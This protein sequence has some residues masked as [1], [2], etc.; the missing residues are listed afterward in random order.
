MLYK[1]KTL[2]VP[3]KTEAHTGFRQAAPRG[4][5]V[6]FVFATTRLQVDNMQVALAN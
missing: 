5:P 4:Q 2:I 3:H 6:C 1:W